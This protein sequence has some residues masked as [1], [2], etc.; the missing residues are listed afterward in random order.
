[1]SLK[2]K[3]TKIKSARLKSFGLPLEIELINLPIMGAEDVAIKIHFSGIN[4]YEL[5]V[6]DG[7][8]PTTPDLPTTPGGEFSGEVLAVGKD[9]TE[10]FKGDR[11]FSLAQTG[12]GTSGSYAQVAIVNQKY[13]YHLPKNISFETGSA[14]PM[15]TFTAYTML[16]RRVTMPKEGSVVVHSAAGGVGSMLV[17]LIKAINPKISIIATCSGEQKAKIVS[18]LGADLVIDTS[19]DEQFGEKIKNKFP[20]GVD[21]IFDPMGQQYI[22]ENLAL[23]NPLNGLI[24]SYGAYTGPISDPLLVGKLRKNNL[25]LSGFLMW[26]ILEDRKLCMNIFKEIFKLFEKKQIRPMIDKIFPLK[27]S[28]QAIDRI[29]QRQNIGKVLIK[30]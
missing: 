24:C 30:P 22:D 9:V 25:T 17:Q 4:F 23:L 28:N 5:M 8:Y 6:M 26:P 11:V 3:L 10:F 15:I 19:K 1:M 12:K 2:E 16:T 27:E 14:F 21:I 18:S 29:R 7:K 20:N 13:L